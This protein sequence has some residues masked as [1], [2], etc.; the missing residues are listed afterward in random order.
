MILEIRNW[1]NKYLLIHLS[2]HEESILLK[3]KKKY[4]VLL[5]NIDITPPSNLCVPRANCRAET[6]VQQ[7]RRIRFFH[8][9][10]IYGIEVN[11]SELRGARAST[12]CT[13][14]HCCAAMPLE[15]LVTML[16]H[17]RCF[18][19][20]S[21]PSSRSFLRGRIYGREISP[22]ALF[23]FSC[24]RKTSREPRRS[25]LRGWNNACV[26]IPEYVNLY[27]Y[28]FIVFFPSFFLPP[29]LFFFI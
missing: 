6:G 20:N 26:H 4:Y 10:L 18:A 25:P 11:G 2:L 22:P 15:C 16:D 5:K 12:W 27:H 1:R 19:K 3:K 14:L 29:S 7:R 28:V 23:P 9:C 13:E 24:S 8:I 21:S 17:E